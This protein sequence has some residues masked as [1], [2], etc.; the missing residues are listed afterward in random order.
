M[1]GCA[2]FLRSDGES[3]INRR[4]PR[5]M[6]VYQGGRSYD[7]PEYKACRR[8]AVDRVRL[9]RHV[10]LCSCCW[11]P[12]SIFR[13]DRYGREERRYIETHHL[14][15]A[16][17]GSLIAVCSSC[18]QSQGRGQSRNKERS[19]LHNSRVWLQFPDRSKNRQALWFIPIV[20]V[21]AGIA[22]GIA[23]TI[24]KMQL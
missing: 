20:V 12:T 10:A 1:D 7:S 19:W 18:H 6:T 15:A 24:R 2:E 8:R 11:R 4:D 16:W 17:H 22:T 21:Q 23:W 14:L 3:M 9:T 5:Q 13:L